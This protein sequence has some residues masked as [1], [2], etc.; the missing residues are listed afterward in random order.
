MELDAN[1]IRQFFFLFFSLIMLY[2]LYYYEINL[3]YQ[4]L[5]IL[6]KGFIHFLMVLLFF[7]VLMG[8]LI[9]LLILKWDYN[10]FLNKFIVNYDGLIYYYGGY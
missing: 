4:I 6:L 7:F 9:A 1:E 10:Y 3:H 8:H 2:A 5:M